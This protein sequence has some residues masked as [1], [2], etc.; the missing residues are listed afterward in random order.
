[1]YSATASQPL[2]HPL[3][4]LSDQHIANSNQAERPDLGTLAIARHVRFWK[5][6]APFTEAVLSGA[7]MLVDNQWFRQHKMPIFDEDFFPL[8][9]GY[10]FVWT[11]DVQR[12]YADLRCRGDSSALLESICGT[13]RK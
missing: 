6:S 1:M 3:W 4:L 9:R 12:G 13:A 2:G 7:C 10:G 8:L 5:E 11:P